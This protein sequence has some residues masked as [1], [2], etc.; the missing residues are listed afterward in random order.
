MILL[1]MI[2]KLNYQSK[3]VNNIAI[4]QAKGQKT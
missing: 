2:F 1:N 4:M 3:Y